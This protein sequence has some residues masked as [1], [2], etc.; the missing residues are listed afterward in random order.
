MPPPPLR[1]GC[2]IK[3]NETIDRNGNRGY[4]FY[5]LNKV[6]RCDLAAKADYRVGGDNLMAAVLG[7]SKCCWQQY[8]AAACMCE[9][10]CMSVCKS[11]LFWTLPYSK[12][13]VR[14]QGRHYRDN[15]A[16]NLQAADD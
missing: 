12:E 4:Y 13:F 16:S 15:E 7:L 10:A 11:L 5:L 3:E 8:Q 9:P 2:Q 6:L 14:K 1:K